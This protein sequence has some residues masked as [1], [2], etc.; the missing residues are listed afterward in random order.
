MEE[1]QEW[2]D[3]FKYEAF[4]EPESEKEKKNW[5]DHI[6]RYQSAW[7]SEYKGDLAD[8]LRETIARTP[9]ARL[10]SVVNSYGTGKSHMV[11][12]LGTEIMTVPMCLCQ[13]RREGFPPLD[14]DLQQWLVSD[15][16]DRVTVQRREYINP[17]GLHGFVYSLLMVTGDHCKGTRW[18][19][20][21]GSDYLPIVS[22][23]YPCCLISEVAQRRYSEKPEECGS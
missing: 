11:D 20:F 9:Y 4:L 8:V 6:L 2:A 22:Q 21:D 19:S 14:E 3:L 12:Q 13:G 5:S 15:S 23:I 1:K 10:T 7:G 16:G 17:C 18:L